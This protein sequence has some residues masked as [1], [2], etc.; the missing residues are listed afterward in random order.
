[1]SE[2]SNRTNASARGGQRAHR[3]SFR[4]DVPRIT[5]EDRDYFITLHQLREI[6][7]DCGFTAK[8]AVVSARAH[9]MIECTNEQAE[10]V[11][12]DLRELLP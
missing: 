7:R 2:L 3:G 9:N 6:M 12:K 1:M 8:Q 5:K 10:Q 4:F 11:E